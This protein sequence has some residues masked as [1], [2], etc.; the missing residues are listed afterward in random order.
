M[1]DSER[2]MQLKKA[3]HAKKM[4]QWEDMCPNGFVDAEIKENLTGK[5]KPIDKDQSHAG[6][7]SSLEE[8][9]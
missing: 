6:G 8:I 2:L 1:V 3:E 5:H 9:L 4:R 7:G